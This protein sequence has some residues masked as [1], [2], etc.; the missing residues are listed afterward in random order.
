M[1]TPGEFWNAK[2]YPFLEYVF[3]KRVAAYVK[4]AWEMIPT[5]MYQAHYSRRSFRG[6]NLEDVYFTRQLNLIIDLIHENN[7]DLSLEELSYL[8]EEE[9]DLDLEDL[10]VDDYIETIIYKLNDEDFFD[11]VN[12]EYE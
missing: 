3:G 11:L 6:S 2:R 5:L 4:K 1:A 12:Y 10:V 7:Y 8:S 9:L